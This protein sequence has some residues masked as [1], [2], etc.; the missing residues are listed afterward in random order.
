MRFMMGADPAS[1]VTNDNDQGVLNMVQAVLVT[2]FFREKV[3]HKP[4]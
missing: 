2:D 3:D 1:M 4:C